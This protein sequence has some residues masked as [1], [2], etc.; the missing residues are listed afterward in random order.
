MVQL[1]LKQSNAV[2]LIRAF[3]MY[4]LAFSFVDTAPTLIRSLLGLTFQSTSTLIAHCYY[5]VTSETPSRPSFILI[6]TSV[7]SPAHR[8]SAQACPRFSAKTGSWKVLWHLVCRRARS[9]QYDAGKRVESKDSKETRRTKCRRR[10]GP[11]SCRYVWLGLE[12][13][14]LCGVVGARSAIDFW[15][16]DKARELTPCVG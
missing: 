1:G 16:R 2:E 5:K 7:R 8:L 12:R 11:F 15:R 13:R 6:L 9:Y 10:R 4:S 14:Q 3:L